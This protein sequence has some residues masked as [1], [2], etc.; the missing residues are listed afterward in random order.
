MPPSVTKPEVLDS[1]DVYLKFLCGTVCH[2]R[3]DRSSLTQTRSS[4]EFEKTSAWPFSNNENRD[5]T[6]FPLRNFNVENARTRVVDEHSQISSTFFQLVKRPELY[7]CGTFQ[8]SFFNI[9]RCQNKQHIFS[10]PDNH[11]HSTFRFFT[12][13]QLLR[14]FIDLLPFPCAMFIVFSHNYI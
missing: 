4:F 12:L 1:S 10:F 9:L 7:A 14:Y 2:R 13:K 3:W 8:I 11:K 6:F 5:M